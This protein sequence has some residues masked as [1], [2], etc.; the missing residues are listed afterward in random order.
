MYIQYGIQGATPLEVLHAC[1]TKI[2]WDVTF[3]DTFA[4]RPDPD[5]YILCFVPS[6]PQQGG[7]PDDDRCQSRFCKASRSFEGQLR[8]VEG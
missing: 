1:S 2:G 5:T 3:A 7:M 4:K 6:Q 8:F